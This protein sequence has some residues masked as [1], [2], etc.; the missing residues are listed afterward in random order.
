MQFTPIFEYHNLLRSH[1]HAIDSMIDHFHRFQI[2]QGSGVKCE[3]CCAV[4]LSGASGELTFGNSQAFRLDKR[5]RGL[6]NDERHAELV[7][8]FLS[9]AQLTFCEMSP[10]DA[11]QRKLD[12]E[13]GEIVYLFDFKTEKDKWKSYKKLSPSDQ[14]TAVRIKA[15]LKN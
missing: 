2:V 4:S 13:S 5:A 14:K 6:A 9:E 7:V 8:Y 1:V 11:C 3:S 15:G 10:C 12:G